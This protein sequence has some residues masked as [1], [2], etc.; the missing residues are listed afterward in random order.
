MVSVFNINENVSTCYIPL[1]YRRPFKSQ[2]YNLW[3]EFPNHRIIFSLLETQLA[4]D[5]LA[6]RHKNRESF[7]NYYLTNVN[8][9]DE[10]DFFEREDLANFGYYY[11]TLKKGHGPAI[12]KLLNKL[13]NASALQKR[14]ILEG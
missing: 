3:C 9:N 2:Q 8:E 13:Q 12:E 11:S 7:E 4:L 14:G 6:G 5:E 10:K 1:V